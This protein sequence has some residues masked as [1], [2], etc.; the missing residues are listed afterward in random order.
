MWRQLVLHTDKARKCRYTDVNLILSSRE[1]LLSALSYRPQLQTIVNTGP[2][3]IGKL[4]VLAL[5]DSTRISRSHGDLQNSLTTAT[6][7][8]DLLGSTQT[9]GIKVEAAIE[10]EAAR[11]LWDQGEMSASIKMLQLLDTSVDLR[12]QT[13]RVGKPELL[14]RLVSS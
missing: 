9:L 2:R 8:S 13:I 1:T 5:L 14:A 10:Y 11:V 3:E 4:H 6:Y 7:L 12:K